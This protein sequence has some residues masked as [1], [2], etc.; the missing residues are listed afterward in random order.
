VGAPWTLAAYA[1]EVRRTLAMVL[2][3]WMGMMRMMV[4][5]Y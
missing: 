2:I 4:V 3:N 5:V 1:V